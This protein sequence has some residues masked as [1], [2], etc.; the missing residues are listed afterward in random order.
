ME[1]NKNKVINPIHSDLGKGYMIRLRD[2][3]LIAL[4]KGNFTQ[5]RKTIVAREFLEFL[6]DYEIPHSK[7]PSES[8][9]I[10]QALSALSYRGNTYRDIKTMKYTFNDKEFIDIKTESSGSI[11][12]FQRNTR[13]ITIG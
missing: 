4:Y 11:A 10:K 13:I 1:S 9:Q 6:K 5:T 3:T 8:L 2:Y 12:N 7:A